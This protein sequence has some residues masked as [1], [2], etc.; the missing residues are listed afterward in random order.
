MYQLRL[1][2]KGGCPKHPRYNPETAGRGA[3][4]GGCTTC[5]ALWS[6]YAQIAIL[7]V[8]TNAADTE[9]AQAREMEARRQGGLF[10]E[11]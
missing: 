4:K 7:K 1:R 9:I 11:N 3:I 8:K 5:E 6:L 2:W 10:H